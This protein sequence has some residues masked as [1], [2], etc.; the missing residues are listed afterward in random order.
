MDRRSPRPD[1]TV[2]LRCNNRC[3]FCPRTILARIAVMPEEGIE[4]RLAAVRRRS[5][6]VVLTGG[7]VTVLEDLFDILAACRRL[8]FSDVA[9]ISN[10]RRFSDPALAGAVVDAGVTEVGVTLYDLRRR[11]HDGLTGVRGS[12]AETLAGLDHLVRLRAQTGKPRLR[13][14]TVLSS[15][16]ADG[17][18][19]LV[20]RVAGRGI[21]DILIAEAVLS[22]VFNEPLAY[23]RVRAIAGTIVR[24][25]LHGASSVLFRG[26]PCCIFRDLP[27]V[28]MGGVDR[29]GGVRVE[30]Q[31][32]DTFFAPDTNAR[33]Y[34][35]E[36]ETG[37]ERV[38]ACR[39]CAMRTVCPGVQKRYLK[40]F[41][42]EDFSPL[43][44]PT[45]PGRRK[46]LPQPARVGPEETGD[47]E[48]DEEMIASEAP[49]RRDPCR[50]A[51]TP[52]TACQLRCSYCKVR[53]GKRTSAPEVLDRAVD[54]L[55][56]SAAARP[57]IQFFGGEPLL[58]WREVR[59]TIER[60][61]SLHGERD[62]LFTLTTNG[63]LLDDDVLAF[64]RETN[65]RV[66][67]SLDG[68]LRTQ[69]LTRLRG[70]R[71][72][73]KMQ[74][75]ME[76]GLEA[77]MRSG[78]P[79]FVNMVFTPE[80]VRSI[81][82][83][84]DF[85][86][87]KGV[88]VLQVCYANGLAWPPEAMEEARAALSR[89]AGAS[90]GQGRFRLQNI[91]SDVEPAILSNDLIVDVDGTLYGDAAIF[92]ERAFPDLRSVYRMGHV[93]QLRC[94]DGLRR[95]KRE[96][97]RL[98]RRTYPRGSDT[99]RM[100]ESQLRF[101]MM[102]DATLRRF[103]GGARGPRTPGSPRTAD[104]NPLS[105][106]FASG[107]VGQAA[108]MEK[109]PQV[110][111][112]P[113]LLLENPC[114]HDCI[115]CKSKPIPPTP[116]GRIRA[117]LGENEG[118]GL[119]RL[120]IVGNEPLAHPD[121]LEVVDE[122]RRCGFETFEVLTSGRP[123]ADEGLAGALAGR[124]VESVA[125]PLYSHIAEAHDEITGSPGSHTA[126]LRAIENARRLGIRVYLHAN[127]LT[128]NLRHLSAL[129]A[130]V[131][132]D[133]GLPFCII[134][135]RPKTANRPYGELVPPYAA[136]IETLAEKVASL[137]GFPLCVTERIQSPALLDA[138]RISDTLKLYVTDQGH[139]KPKSRCTG[140]AVSRRCIGTY[141]EMIRLYGE[142]DLPGRD[143]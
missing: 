18:T 9:L 95:T 20:A 70:R 3:V 134:P 75:A 115:F 106:V 48:L 53:L 111:K 67:F 25:G 85:M 63:L 45:R 143:R 139:A 43:P 123:L 39:S 108:F 122:A 6:R 27:G 80:N 15:R 82:S 125:M 135:T 56:T 102:V 126:T 40:S 86:R 8:G 12:L 35:R 76:R 55:M 78:V 31:A 109:H 127:L 120:G 37:F 10:G 87:R 61:R 84:V 23:G 105:K 138:S 66:I 77:L 26:F 137:V 107:L 88:G 51:V 79:F 34:I 133:L 99:R 110:M 90:T 7:E 141:A 96:N 16:N 72:A 62:V 24:E 4:A 36:F 101:G 19:G 81:E 30:A 136:V 29:P 98:L 32:I 60:T 119:R 118:L 28:S 140:C 11:V 74:A 121:I 142:E 52:T 112:L 131:V 73:P 1:I 128:Q 5:D 41:G 65:A 93:A 46:D 42:R 13:I 2:T 47:D 44:G 114:C 33:R 50:I 71:D 64:L 116:M 91:G 14:N 57:E 21:Q 104:A 124:G 89:L 69:A 38:P 54:L 103:E 22:D 129:E 83:N 94:Y 113:V 97:L 117:M 130:L 49:E 92:C 59:R 68:D 100:I 58:G 17:M 132:R